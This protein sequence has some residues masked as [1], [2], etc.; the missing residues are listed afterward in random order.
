[1]N[2]NLKM[3]ILVFCLLL[4]P[5]ITQ[6]QLSEQ[7]THVYSENVFNS[8]YIYTPVFD[9][10]SNIYIAC[11]YKAPDSSETSRLIK[12]D[13]KGKIVWEYD[14]VHSGNVNQTVVGQNDETALT[15]MEFLNSGETQLF[16]NN[17]NVSGAAIWEQTYSQTNH[18]IWSYNSCFN[19][20]GDFFVSGFTRI[21]DSR[22]SEDIIVLAYSP[23]GNFRWAYSFDGALHQQDTD[24]AIVGDNLGNIFIVGSE[25]VDEDIYN[26]CTTLSNHL[27]KFNN[28]GL[29]WNVAVPYKSEWAVNSAISAKVDNSNNLIF[30]SIIISD[31][32]YYH[33]SQLYKYSSSGSL[34]WNIVT[35][36]A[37]VPA[38]NLAKEIVVDSYNNIIVLSNGE[39]WDDLVVH[40]YS[41]DGVELWSH[42]YN[43]QGA[44]RDISVNSN[45]DIYVVYSSGAL[46][47]RS[48]GTLLWEYALPYSN[49]STVNKKG[50]IALSIINT[51]GFSIIMYSE[52]STLTLK[53]SQNNT[54][55]NTD[56]YLI[57]VADDAPN[58]T[59]DTL[60]VV[61]TDS[62]GKIKL[63]PLQ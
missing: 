49:Y 15:G 23:T 11:T 41:S 57:K 53:D 44:P 29:V 28:E 48:D 34:L 12:F 27:F 31:G 26:R 37:S 63:K 38:N 43:G 54:L 61:T 6:A 46:K 3:L 14:D 39:S 51:I 33:L 9:K 10:E 56:F 4:I 20:T 42:T 24:G 8:M 62:D 1:M 45:G 19:S 35:D 22:N 5:T 50:Q 52:S 59:P 60:G 13:K 2:N 36:S 30:M 21:I 25:C 40:K 7:W 32:N 17:I 18:Q 55:S 16:F 58:Y 47:L